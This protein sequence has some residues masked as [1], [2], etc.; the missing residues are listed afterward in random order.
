MTF[1]RNFDMI[2]MKLKEVTIEH[3]IEKAK[4]IAIAAHE[5][6]TRNNGEPYITHPAAVAAA[7]ELRLQPIAWLH[8]VV[9]DS[10]VTLNDLKQEGFPS[11]IIVAIDLLTHK[12]NEPN[13]SYWAN[14]ATNLDALEVKKKDIAHNMGSNPS[15]HAKRKYAKALVFFAQKSGVA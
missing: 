6:Q 9:E 11:Y 7:V 10:A 12:N 4:Q 1:E 15:E 5:G 8:D 13:M 14:I 3:W 2:G